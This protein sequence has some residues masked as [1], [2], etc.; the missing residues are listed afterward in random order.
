MIKKV[1]APEAFAG[2]GPR[3]IGGRWNSRGTSVVYAAEHL[4]LAALEMFVG[5]SRVE[6]GEAFYAYPL[7]I[8]SKVHILTLFP[9]SLPLDWRAVK[10]PESTKTVGDDW[11]RAGISSILRVPSVI[12]PAEYNLILNPVH[13]DFRKITIGQP[14]NFSFDPR[15][16]K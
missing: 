8:P 10:H 15:M 9:S 3:I 1:F 4:S 14:E 16:W 2:E 13:P 7:D 11:V 5:L 6:N 12:I